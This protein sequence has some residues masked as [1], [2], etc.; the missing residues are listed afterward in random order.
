M[1]LSFTTSGNIVLFSGTTVSTEKSA[2]AADERSA[3]L[4]ESLTRVLA[5]GLPPG[6]K[7]FAKGGG[8]APATKADPD[9][10]KNGDDDTS[11]KTDK[12]HDYFPKK[13]K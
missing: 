9:P 11:A 3:V 13:K 10:D 7:P 4:N 8:K 2:T 12:D 1:T 6:F 5:K